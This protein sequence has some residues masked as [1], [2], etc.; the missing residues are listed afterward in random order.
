[1][2]RGVSALKWQPIQTDSRSPIARSL[3]AL[4]R[5]A[6]PRLF[7]IRRG[8]DYH[9]GRG[10]LHA[11][12]WSPT[13]SAAHRYGQHNPA[14]SRHVTPCRPK[15]GRRADDVGLAFRRPASEPG[16][17][18]VL[19][20]ADDAL[21]DVAPTHAARCTGLLPRPCDRQR[22]SAAMEH[23]L[24]ISLRARRES[25]RSLHLH[26]L[27]MP[28]PPGARQS[29]FG[30][31]ATSPRGVFWNRTVMASLLVIYFSPMPYRRNNDLFPD[32]RRRSPA[33]RRREAVYRFVLRVASHRHGRSLQTRSIFYLSGGAHPATA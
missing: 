30:R 20:S 3:T 16:L 8:N 5:R 31:I 28:W 9:D 15:R 27:Q 32:P 7:R 24:E 6:C 25:V 13:L 18:T 10:R 19:E 33:S 4:D 17:L 12:R 22:P 21:D 2:I 26:P 11:A 14:G 29:F 23:H 1:M